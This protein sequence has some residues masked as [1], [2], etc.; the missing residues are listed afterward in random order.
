MTS[1]DPVSAKAGTL[2][3]NPYVFFGGRC[4]EA[5]N[6][7]KAVLDGSWEG[8]RVGE[9]PMADTSPPEW[10]DK[11]MHASFTAP[12]IKF[13]AA[14]GREAQKIDPDAGNIT[15]SLTAANTDAGRR[16]FE[17]L[18]QGGEVRMQFEDA[19]WGGQ[20][21]MLVDRFGVEWMVVAN[22]PS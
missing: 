22:P 19:F 12:G 1:T 6:F 3:L 2:E 11:F 7:Y 16:L 18:S 10:R 5:L 4:E 8:M 21:G 14:D 20:F 9:S 15:L 17:A 13:F